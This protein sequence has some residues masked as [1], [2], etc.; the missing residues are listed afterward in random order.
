MHSSVDML[1]SC[2][3]RF[4]VT[5]PTARV[6]TMR[7]LLYIPKMNKGSQNPVASCVD[8]GP[9]CRWSSFQS[10]GTG[11]GERDAASAG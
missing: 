8:S 11:E 7:V 5:V 2:S 4:S 1:R 6:K 10:A 3:S 9:L